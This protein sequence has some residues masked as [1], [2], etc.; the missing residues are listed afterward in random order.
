MTSG[1]GLHSDLTVSHRPSPCSCPGT[2]PTHA[3]NTQLALRLPV[4]MSP[5]IGFFSVVLPSQKANDGTLQG[6]GLQAWP[7]SLREMCLW[8]RLCGAQNV[9]PP[10]LGRVL[11]WA[12]RG[13]LR[14][15]VGGLLVNSCGWRSGLEPAP[16]APRAERPHP[17]GRQTSCP[18]GGCE[19]RG[20]ILCFP[21]DV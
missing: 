17:R 21:E 5:R 14:R 13:F 8:S 20:F 10:S 2:P 6:P 18:S 12:P 9:T 1:Q 7:P 15:Q 4:F 3:P 11:C 19:C 16:Q